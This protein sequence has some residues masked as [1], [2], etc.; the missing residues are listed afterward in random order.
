VPPPE[1]VV[2]IPAAFE[3]EEEWG[4]EIVNL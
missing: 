1:P 2:E 3:N 4:A